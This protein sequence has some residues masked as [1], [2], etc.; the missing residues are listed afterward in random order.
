MA[1]PRA[2]IADDSYS[3]LIE[4]PGVLDR[5]KK[6]VDGRDKSDHY[7]TPD[8]FFPRLAMAWTAYL[9]P[10]LKDGAEVTAF[11]CAMLMAQ[12]KITR[13]SV[14]PNHEDS[15]TDLGGYV[16]IGERVK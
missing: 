7:G 4:N 2:Q 3:T 13:L 6:L 16:H 12:L 15:L 14:N 11:D 10:R 1:K 8:E 5:A 9:S